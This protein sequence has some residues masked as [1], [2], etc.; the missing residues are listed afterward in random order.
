VRES[1]VFCTSLLKGIS[2]ESPEPI[3]KRGLRWRS[4]IR[5]KLEFTVTGSGKKRLFYPRARA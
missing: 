4:R 2:P 5:V 3:P 1:R